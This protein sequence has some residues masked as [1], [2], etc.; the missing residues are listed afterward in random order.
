MELGI[1]QIVSS[2]DK[3]EGGQWNLTDKQRLALMTAYE[4]GYF[5]VPRTTSLTDLA[6]GF[7]ITHQAFSRRLMRGLDSV[8]TH[9][10][11]AE[12]ELVERK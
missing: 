3:S 10:L 9:T 8:L 6:D 4:A 12:T 5:T 11:V 1:Q 2:P 7:D